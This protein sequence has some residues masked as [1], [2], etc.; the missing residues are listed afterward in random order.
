MPDKKLELKSSKSVPAIVASNSRSNSVL[1]MLKERVDELEV[2][3]NRECE[4]KEKYMDYYVDGRAELEKVENRIKVLEREKVILDSDVRQLNIRLKLKETE[5]ELLN[6]GKQEKTKRIS[7]L[8]YQLKTVEEKH[9]KEMSN[10]IEKVDHRGNKEIEKLLKEN[11]WLKQSIKNKQEEI[12]RLKISSDETTEREK[13]IWQMKLAQMERAVALADHV[14]TEYRERAQ[15][16]IEEKEFE[17]QTLKTFIYN[18]QT[19]K[20]KSKSGRRYNINVPVNRS[21][22]SKKRLNSSKK[23]SSQRKKIW[24]SRSIALSRGASIDDQI[25]GT[26]I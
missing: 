11:E 16:E 15:N 25:S 8:L 5:I 14:Y 21:V 22:E 24:R 12:T 1:E 10:R 23:S 26:G 13:Q 18:E 19:R 9:Q 17:L 2:L 4:E 7:E 3:F 6:K 20:R